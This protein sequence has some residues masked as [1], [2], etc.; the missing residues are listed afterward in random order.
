V[1]K[2]TASNA[3]GTA[4]GSPVSLSIP[5]AAACTTPTI[6]AHSPSSLAAT[7]IKGQSAALSITVA[8]GELAYQWYSNTTAS[9]SGGSVI[10]G[11]T[12]A[13]Y[14]TSATLSVGTHY[15]FC[16][17]TRTCNSSYV[18]SSVFTVTVNAPA[19]IPVG[20]GTLSGRTCFDVAQSNNSGECGNLT[21]R[22][23][24]TLSA[25]GSRADF[26]TT[27]TNSQ[28]YTF[29]PSGTVSNVRFVY[30]EASA[31][32][33]Q[34]V[35]SISGGNTGNNITSAVSCTV[36]YKSTLNSAADGKNNSNALTV[37]IYAIYNDGPTNNGT[38]KSVKLTAKI[39]DC[40]CC[41]AYTV[42][43]TWLNFMCYNLGA[44]PTI[45]SP[46]AQQAATPSSVYGSYYGWGTS[47]I[48]GNGT[49]I[50]SAD[51]A[52]TAWGDGAAKT[53]NDPCP[54]GWR[55][56][57]QA[58]WES[59]LNGNSGHIGLAND[60]TPYTTSSGNV[61]VWKKTTTTTGIQIGNYLFLPA[62][63]FIYSSYNCNVYANAEQVRYSTTNQSNPTLRYS[64]TARDPELSV[65]A[66][67]NQGAVVRCVEDK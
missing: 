48:A 23:S 14:S 21:G 38:D 12:S 13:A 10:T 40:P 20:S 35:Q 6:S 18:L 2:L 41:G 64:S 66:Y 33:G 44:D 16:R 5:V 34:I 51:A 17:A 52:A 37:D 60:G 7:V 45:N 62:A 15:F 55:V 32:S 24:E 50:Y 54:A 4:T 3:C 22:Q 9:T 11:A 42:D 53:S 67:G 8:G 19:A 28:T 39:K 29:T 27:T 61:V 58:Q 31:Y 25:N 1:L 57:S 49:C 65:S 56:P 59:I 63:G 30:D 46:A 47:S 36:H 26:A 43:G